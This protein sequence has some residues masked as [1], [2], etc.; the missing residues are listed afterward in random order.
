MS[1]NI[2]IESY[3]PNWAIQFQ[4]IKDLIWPLVKNSALA[5]E[6]VGSTSIVGL[7]AKPIIDIDIIIPDM[8]YLDQVVKS[9]SIIGY[10][11]RGNLGIE[12]REVF[13]TLQPLHKH[14]LY[15]CSKDSIA[16]NNHL[17]LRDVLRTN[18]ALRDE[19]AAIKY[20][21]AEKFPD[22]ID[23]YVEG[24]T[25]F[26]LK[27][28]EKSENGLSANELETIRSANLSPVKK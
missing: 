19:Y 24:K 23:A 16:L 18:S 22:S 12:N 9:L 15:V 3:N 21:L 28:L 14:N 6:H 20:G 25:D 13:K 8:S 5:I 7:A 11:H 27:I 2:I 4:E 10:E 17:T 26:I 1:Q